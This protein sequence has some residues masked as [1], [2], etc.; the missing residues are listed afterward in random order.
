[1]WKEF[2][3]C[4]LHRLQY[5]ARPLIPLVS[6]TTGHAHPAFPRTILAFH[7]LTSDQLDDLSR[8]YHQVWP[9]VPET[10]SYPLHVPAWV[11][12][13]KEVD[14]DTKR[15]RF[16]RFIGLQ[17]YQSPVND[18]L[19]ESEYNELEMHLVLN[20]MEREWQAAMLRAILC[21]KAI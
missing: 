4:F 5:L 8:H 17:D 11:G 1:M 14:L 18:N 3:P 13:R 9:P 6:V 16:G 20:Y 10:Y 15:H 12:T 21:R 19:A 2:H 7:L